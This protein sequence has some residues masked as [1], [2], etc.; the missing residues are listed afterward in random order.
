[1]TDRIL[2]TSAL[3]YTNG[4]KHIGGAG[5]AAARLVALVP[6]GERAGDIRHAVYAFPIRGGLLIWL[7][8]SA[9]SQAACCHLPRRDLAAAYR[10]S[11]NPPRRKLA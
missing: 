3:P 6:D 8:G 10:T 7:T 1:M 5:R 4:I 11:A 9:T 2:V